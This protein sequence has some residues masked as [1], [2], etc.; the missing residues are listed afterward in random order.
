MPPLNDK[1]ESEPVESPAASESS[2]PSEEQ[3]ERLEN[4]SE[5]FGRFFAHGHPDPSSWIG[6]GLDGTLAHCEGEID[7][8]HIGPPVADMVARVRDWTDRGHTVKVFTPRAAS[9]EGRG[10][11]EQWL[12]EHELPELEVTCEKDLHMLEVWDSRTVQVIAN[13]GQPVGQSRVEQPRQ[14]LADETLLQEEGDSPKESD[15]TAQ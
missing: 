5:E 9:E 1:P 7:P 11:V 13:S 2:P 10:Q 4:F 15:T 12:R 6:V 14:V 8:A 3:E